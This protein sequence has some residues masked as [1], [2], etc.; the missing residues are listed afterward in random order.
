MLELDTQTALLAQS[1]PMNTQM[2]AMLK[3]FTNSSIS[4]MQVKA[5]QELKCDFCG[6]DMLMVNAFLKAPRKQKYLA[7]FKKSNPNNNPYSNTYNPGWRE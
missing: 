1:T 6:R 3:H 7:K 2:A 4:Q 5:A